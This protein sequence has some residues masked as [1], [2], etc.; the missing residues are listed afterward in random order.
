MRPPPPKQSIAR[1][2]KK[3]P[4]GNNKNCSRQE[5]QWEEGSGQT[6]FPK[7]ACYESGWE[8]KPT[9][10]VVLPK[11]YAV[12]KKSAV[13]IKSSAK[14]T[15]AMAPAKP[16]TKTRKVVVASTKKLVELA[17]ARRHGIVDV[18]ADVI[19]LT[20][21]PSLAFNRLFL[22]SPPSLKPV[23]QFTAAALMKIVTMVGATMGLSTDSTHSP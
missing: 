14:T 1:K 20:S 18:D 13:A 5:A 2:A 16:P 11:K 15:A 7:E 17:C 19:D 8:K 3:V 6:G 4:A 22:L 23:Q 21:S 9:Q 12:A 10:K